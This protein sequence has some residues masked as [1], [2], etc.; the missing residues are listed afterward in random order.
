MRS[1]DG[2]PDPTPS[3]CEA[4]CRMILSVTE[5]LRAAQGL[6]ARIPKPKNIAPDWLP[7][8]DWTPEA[9][10]EEEGDEPA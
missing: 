1:F 4:A 5:A 3:E 8:E 7:P 2:K 10:Q 9:D 6:P